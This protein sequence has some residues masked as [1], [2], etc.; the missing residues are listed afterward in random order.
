VEGKMNIQLHKLTAKE[1]VKKGIP[2]VLIAGI[3]LAGVL[4]WKGEELKNVQNYYQIKTIFPD[5]GFVDDIDDG[6][7]FILKSGVKVRLLGVNAPNRG[8]N[9][10]EQ[11]KTGLRELIGN[12]KVYLEYD[13]YQADKY[14]RVLAWIWID[15]EEKPK[16]QPAD[17]MHLS[18]N[19]SRSGLTDNPDG[20]KQGKLV[21][22]EMVQLGLV[23]TEKYQDRGELKY[24]T[25]IKNNN[26]GI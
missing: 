22:E 16:F 4:G 5:V 9:G 24:E 7:T 1:L 20:C 2:A 23:K 19:T 17:Y 15:C 11:S 8:V 18:G 21:N 13:R 25:R 12:N 3:I 14:G 10:F 6:D 26:L